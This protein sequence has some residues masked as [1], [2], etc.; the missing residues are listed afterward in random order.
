MD[1]SVIIVSYDSRFFLELCLRSLKASLI[2]IKSEIIVVDNNSNDDTIDMIESSFFEVI[3]IRNK[4][5][6][7][8]S[9]ANNL[10]AKKA[11]GKNI[12]FLNPDTVVPEDFFRKI[13]D[14]KKSTN[15]VG[16]VACK[17]IDG[18]GIFLPESKRN[19]PN[20]SMVIKK[21]FGLK[22]NYYSN[23]QSED[24]IGQVDVLCGAI[25][26]MER[27]VFEETGGFD[28]KYFMFGED[29]DL[30]YKILKKGLKNYY[31]GDASIIHYKGESTSKNSKYYKS[32]YGAMGIYYRKYISKNIFSN[33]LSFLILE[34][35]I[36]FKSFTI[37]SKLRSRINSHECF[38]ISDNDYVGLRNRV[39]IK[40]ESI[41]KL[42]D[43]LEN[44]E[45]IFDSNYLTFKNIIS[46]MQRLSKKK[47][48]IFKILPQASNFLIGTY[49]SREHGQVILFDLNK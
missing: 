11:K 10:A 12:C 16:I 43:K 36:F 3:L 47:G 15:N 48:V 27:K 20:T 41:E 22:N 42:S 2:N 8:F 31:Y 30:S 18:Q 14:F 6:V 21:F 35:I 49:S 34:L 39:T 4:F 25:M 44:C 23:K 24:A 46:T 37:T 26:F 45:I 1:L 17:M 7:G 29:I 33:I 28:E 5:N 40:I 38:L 19:L 13:I 9:S 32:F